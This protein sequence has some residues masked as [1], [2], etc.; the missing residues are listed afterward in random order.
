MCS[1]ELGSW[2][3]WKMDRKDLSLQSTH[4]GKFIRDHKG[5]KPSFHLLVEHSQVPVSFHLYIISYYTLLELY[6]AELLA[7]I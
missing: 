3:R 5:W 2:K 6:N 7:S 4:C 1:K